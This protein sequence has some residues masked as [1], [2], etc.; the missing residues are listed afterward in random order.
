MS[1]RVRFKICGV[2]TRDEA[3]LAV[4]AGA[5]ALGFVPGWPTSEG[6]LDDAQIGALM[7]RVPEGVATV[8]LTPHLRA[9]DMVKQIKRCGANTV[10]ICDHVSVETRRAVRNDCPGV[11]L[12]Q[13]V[14]MGGDVDMETVR[15]LA[16]CSDGLLLDSGISGTSFV[17]R[18][19]TGRVHDWEKSRAVVESVTTPVW[20][21]GGLRAENVAQAVEQVRPFGVDVCSGLR[22]GGH[23]SPGRVRAFVDVLATLG[24]SVG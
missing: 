15:R 12:L 24:K 8:L 4:A 18:G 11:R 2:G 5:D 6:P 17:E 13:V 23:L 19:G 1:H 14:H 10:Q 9:S 3:A 22:E 7:E 21:A 20:L 16:E